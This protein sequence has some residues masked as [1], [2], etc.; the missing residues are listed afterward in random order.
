MDPAFRE[1]YEVIARLRSPEGCPWDR[2][3]TLESIK[4]HTLEETCELLDAID[5]GDDEHI[6]EE[7]G[8]VL[9]QVLLDAQIGADEG[10]FSLLEVVER[11]TRKLVDRHPHVFADEHAETPDEVIRTWD[12]AKQREKAGRASIFDGIPSALPQL[13]RAEKLS[14]RAAKV[15]FDF[16]DREMLFDKLREEIDELRRELHPDGAPTP[17]AATAD[18]PPIPDEP[19]DD[20]DRRSR[21]E[22][23]LGDLL[24]VVANIARRWDVNPEEA[25]RRSN[26]KFQDRV[27]AIEVRLAASG[28][29]LKDTTLAE[30]EA[31]YQSAKR[32]V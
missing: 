31:L 28:R 27:T 3:Q 21:I 1:L 2:V 32:P 11:L 24:F 9:L 15:G 10:R 29:S 14:K 18:T 4:P 8:D 12:A 25:L 30:M 20:P 17:V 22:D 16:P 6:I 23:E 13:A 26:R 5:S 19:I 7:L